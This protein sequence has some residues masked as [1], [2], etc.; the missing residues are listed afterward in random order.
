MVHTILIAEPIKK[1]MFQIHLCILQPPQI[2]PDFQIAITYSLGYKIL[3]YLWQ[4]TEAE[5]LISSEV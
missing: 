1:S 2:Q 3:Y 4:N 5:C